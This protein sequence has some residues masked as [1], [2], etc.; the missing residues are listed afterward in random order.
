MENI[1]LSNFH[2]IQGTIEE[3]DLN[4]EKYDLI[5][6]IDVLEHVSCPDSLFKEMYKKLRLG[7]TAFI[8]TS[9]LYYS[10]IGHHCWGFYPRDKYPWV[11]LYDPNFVND[12]IKKDRWTADVLIN[13]NKLT[14]SKILTIVSETGFEIVKK[15]LYMV[16]E[17]I[18]TL[19]QRDIIMSKVENIEDLYVEGMNL[20]LLKR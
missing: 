10:P 20:V 16:N 17:R 13:L 6:M 18:D 14:L 3:L 4:D 7:G 5:T 9:P 11:H 12:I 2:R 15:D 19:A 8:S 1:D